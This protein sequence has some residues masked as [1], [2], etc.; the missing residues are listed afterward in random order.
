M[1]IKYLSQSVFNQILTSLKSL[2]EKQNDKATDTI[3]ITQNQALQMLFDIKFLFA[4]FDIKANQTTN[5]NN[6]QIL[7][8]EFKSVCALLESLVDPFDY[9]ICLPFMQ[10]NITKAINRSTALYGVLNTNERL[11]RNTSSSTTNLTTSQEF[12]LYRL[13]VHNKL[14]YI[15]FQVILHVSHGKNNIKL[16]I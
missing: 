9:D 5:E 14:L 15:T 11:L 6:K 16:K 13:F 7:I 12:Q 8:E 4:L 3:K 10:S 2:L 1:I